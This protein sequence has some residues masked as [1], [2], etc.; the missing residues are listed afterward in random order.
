M[1][2]YIF[3]SLRARLFLLVFIA[4][5]P[6]FFLIVYTN[7]SERRKQ[8]AMIEEQTMRITRLAANQQERFT[9]SARD[10]LIALSRLEM[11]RAG[12]EK[13]CRNLFA[14]LLNRH[15]EYANIGVLD[16]RGQVIMSGV[17]LSE[18]VNW[19]DQDWFK[20]ARSSRGFSIGN[21][22]IG[23][24]TGRQVLFFGQAVKN[25]TSDVGLV[26][27]ATL[28]VKWISEFADAAQLPENHTFCV[29][30]AKGTV[31]ATGSAQAA[32]LRQRNPDSGML[33]QILTR[34][35]GSFETENPDGVARL[36]VFSSLRVS[37]NGPDV[38][39]SIGIP[40]AAVH[41]DAR[42]ALRR[43]LISLGMVAV[44]A[45]AAAW[46]VG[47]RFVMREVNSIVATTN[48]MAAGDLAARN[49]PKYDAS[50]LGFLA[51][52]FDQMADALEK[53]I[54]ELETARKSLSA[55]E[56]KYG[57]LIETTLTGYVE[58]DEMGQVIE[59][60][61]EYVRL[62]GHSSLAE[63]V[64]RKV[65]EWTAPHDLAR[66]ADEVR[67]C[68][69]TGVVRNLELDYIDRDGNLT[70]IEVS[71]SVIET[72]EG[73]RIVSLCRDIS[74]RKKAQAEQTRMAEII[75]ATPDFVATATPNEHIEFVNRAIRSG[76]G[77]PDEEDVR[78][79]FI[80][81]YHDEDA[82]RMISGEAIPTAIRDGFWRGDSIWLGRDGRE[83]PVS[84]VIIA[85]KNE[86]GTVSHISMVA[87]DITD[88]RRVE[89]QLLATTGQM[90]ALSAHMQSIREKEGTRI[91]REIHDELGAAMTGLRWDV[92]AIEHAL[93]LPCK[94]NCKIVTVERIGA[95]KK[96]IDSTIQTMRRIS[97][98]LRP[99]VLDDL[100]LIAAIEW[101][102]EQFQTRSGIVC[103]TVSNLEEAALDKDKSTAV[104]RVYQE[105]LT[106]VMRHARA[107]VVTVTVSQDES[108]FLLE[109]SDN[110]RGIRG[111]DFSAPT[112]FGI[113]GMRERMSLVGGKI[114]FRSLPHGG[115]SVSVRVPI[116]PA[117]NK[118]AFAV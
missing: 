99:G 103:T 116:A 95:I 74:D 80:R 51:R 37:E 34:K 57:I 92:E 105:I 13:E 106:N 48:R 63:I 72:C 67:R 31:L 75:A 39:V 12:N 90:R 81:E 36:H 114:E 98:D 71:G 61:A 10:L 112:S 25:G 79:T 65:T 84:Q 33:Q 91:A 89:Q 41:A 26:L 14:D 59:A 117:A 18:P 53:R 47:N 24:I 40:T 1:L 27:F 109:V 5:A 35:V 19:G 118:A 107:T 6:A 76:L 38:F 93:H 78:N 85:H 55:C 68:I 4:S 108:G 77:I 2:A 110:G 22:Q 104:F 58:L 111:A 7:L 56:G 60:N 15:R 45:Y 115:T 66:N 101:Q 52:S 102:T 54:H 9:N 11:V 86:D 43:D 28:D 42:A 49:G 113:L 32:R 97:S 82:Y 3:S 17:P 70:P 83:I 73:K 64:G 21:Y 62:S 29:L 88:R 96:L 44:M 30:D 69:A 23:K 8:I 46:F 94:E 50:E 87:R 16:T 100:G 20:E